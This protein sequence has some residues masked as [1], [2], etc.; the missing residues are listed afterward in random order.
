M[1]KNDFASWFRLSRFSLRCLAIPKRVGKHCSLAAAVNMQLREELDVPIQP[2]R[3][4][5]ASRDVH[6]SL[7]R[8][9]SSKLVKDDYKDAVQLP[10]SEDTM[11]ELSDETL[12]AIKAKHLPSH[13]DASFPYHLL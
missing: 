2:P 13:T 3:Q 4:L 9:A 5:S 12:S 11:A 8:R 1:D 6:F 10:C 7:A